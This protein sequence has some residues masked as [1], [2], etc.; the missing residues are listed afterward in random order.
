MISAQ[1]T[2]NNSS[3]TLGTRLIRALCCEAHLSLDQLKDKVNASASEIIQE[4]ETLVGLGY[5]LESH[6]YYGISL[7]NLSSAP[8][9]LIADE[10]SA[11]S[12]GAFA[13]NIRV[14]N[15]LDS[16]NLFLMREGS[17]DLKH[18]SC[19]IAEKQ[20]SGRGRLGR[21]WESP[22]QKGLWVSFLLRPQPYGWKIEQ[23]Q[24]LTFI[25]AI[26]LHDAITKC[27]G[28]EVHIKWPNDI[29]S[30]AHEGCKKIA[31]ILTETSYQTGREPFAI[32]GLG[33]NINHSLEDFPQE[34][35]THA[36][37]LH[38]LS[39]KHFRRAD[40]LVELIHALDQ[41]FHQP[42]EKILQAWNDRCAHQNKK[43][44]VYRGPEKLSGKMIKID[45]NG[46]LV[47]QDARGKVHTIASGDV[48]THPQNK[49]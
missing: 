19:V 45:N 16:T 1:I 12:I 40:V 15:E 14:F 3:S 20:I 10:I 35:Q 5:P 31:G 21:T 44:T 13:S 23:F 39:G 48:S 6:P 8:D 42:W 18:G 49:A 46:L 47:L 22:A 2:T 24:R 30:N 37:S 28:L 9:L 11:R 4:I 38:M 34:L 17:H 33:C 41:R 29:I 32:V 27:T 36:T 25:A 43:L 26:A 7:D